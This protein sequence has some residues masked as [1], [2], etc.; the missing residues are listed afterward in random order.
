M[1]TYMTERE[2]TK[3]AMAAGKK[4]REQREN[5]RALLDGHKPEASAPSDGG[6]FFANENGVLTAEAISPAFRS[7]YA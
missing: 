4:L 2:K 5:L 6:W 3:L 7:T 1:T